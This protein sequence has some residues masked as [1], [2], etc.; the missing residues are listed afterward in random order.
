MLLLQEL[1]DVFGRVFVQP[2][3]HR[4]GYTKHAALPLMAETTA[5]G[6]AMYACVVHCVCGSPLWIFAG[7]MKCKH[8]AAAL[9]TALLPGLMAITG[10]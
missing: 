6:V 2:A 3:L 10:V 7:D 9:G 1:L 8:S 4:Q 5:G